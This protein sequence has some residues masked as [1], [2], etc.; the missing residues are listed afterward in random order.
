MAN[1]PIISLMLLKLAHG[2]NKE[3]N[4]KYLMLMLLLTIPYT[5]YAGSNLDGSNWNYTWEVPS[6]CQSLFEEN[7]YTL[8]EGEKLRFKY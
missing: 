8:I 7:S 6:A 5:T 1:T 2:S 3:Y 4:M